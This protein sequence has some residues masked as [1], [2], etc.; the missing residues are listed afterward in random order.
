MGTKKNGAPHESYYKTQLISIARLNC[1]SPAYLISELFL[2][3]AHTREFPATFK[4]TSKHWIV[5]IAISASDPD[6]MASK[7]SSIANRQP[8]FVYLQ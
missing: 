1:S 6:T 8:R 4:M 7:S 3:M 5:A 2:T